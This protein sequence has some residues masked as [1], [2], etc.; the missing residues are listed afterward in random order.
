MKLKNKF[1]AGLFVAAALLFVLPGAPAAAGDAKEVTL[2]H[3][4]LTLGG[5]LKMADGKT[6]ADGVILITHG[7]LAHNRMEI[8]ATMQNLMAERGWNS[9]AITLSLGIDKRRG[10]YDCKVPHKHLH[11]DALD[12][13]GQ[14]LKWLK[15][16]GAQNIVLMGHSRG[17]NQTA[18]FAAER[19][20]PSIAKVVLL[21]PATWNKEA[22]RA[23]YKK[24]FGVEAAPIVAK[25][26]KLIAAGKSSDMLNKIGIVYCKD[27]SATAA[28]FV[29]YHKPDP[30]FHTPTLLGKIKVPALVIAGSEDKVVKGLVDA[31]KPLA[32]GKRISLKVVDEANHYFLD[33]AAE[34]A[35]DAIGEFLKKQ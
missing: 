1:V 35:A 10:M 25:A 6:L 32:D 11:T 20:D 5:N 23:G 15:G 7:T 24:R 22:A 9:L 31:V 8:I 30:R 29:S 28:S 14:W 17:G 21:A 12:E 3:K 26:E 33:F 4:G 19:P 34:D 2:A 16:K 27:A 18:W 13:I